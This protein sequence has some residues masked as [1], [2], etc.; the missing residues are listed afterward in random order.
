LPSEQAAYSYQLGSQ[1]LTLAL[2][3]TNPLRSLSFDDLITLL[4]GDDATWGGF[5]QH[6]ASCSFSEE[7][8]ASFDGEIKL[9]IYYEGSPYQNA[10]VEAS[11]LST[12]SMN[13]ALFIPS[14]E[15]LLTQLQL[16]PN[17]VGFLPSHWLTSAIISVQISNLPAASLELPILALLDQQ[18]AGEL[19][20]LLLCLQSS[21]D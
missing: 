11:G 13:G 14:A 5:F 17:A 9:Y 1:S 16:E 20:E 7:G 8:S 10:V 12:A 6:C 4:Q 3:A 15:A 2:N 21:L 18:P 19:K